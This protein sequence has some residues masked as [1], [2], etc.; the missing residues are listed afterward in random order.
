PTRRSS[1]LAVPQPADTPGNNRNQRP[2]ATQKLLPFSRIGRVGTGFSEVVDRDSRPIHRA[3]HQFTAWARKYRFL[4]AEL[5]PWVTPWKTPLVHSRAFCGCA[6][7]PASHICNFQKRTQHG[8]QPPPLDPRRDSG[9][10][11]PTLPDI[12]SALRRNRRGV[13]RR[14]AA[15]GSFAD[16]PGGDLARPAPDG[17]IAVARLDLH[18]PCHASCVSLRGN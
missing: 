17:A 8:K 13:C 14:V 3:G 16:R 11:R 15:G 18:R 6:S 10:H 9:L 4:V 7:I 5:S 2:R 12:L 1:D